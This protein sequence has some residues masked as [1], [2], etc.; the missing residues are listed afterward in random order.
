MDHINQHKLT[1]SEWCAIEIPVS[2]QE[3]L[4]LKMIQ[5]GYDNVNVKHNSHNSLFTFLKIEYSKHMEDYLYNKFFLDLVKELMQK[6]DAPFLKTVVDAKASIC[7]ADSIR[8]ERNAT[9][10]LTVDSVYELQL[11]T[12]I[13]KIL[14]YH[15]KRDDQWMH[16]YF[17][18]QKLVLNCVPLL[19]CNI[20]E[21]CKKVLKRFEEDIDYPKIIGNSVEYI[22]R[23]HLLL[24]YEDSSLYSHQKDIFT[25]VRD[26][27]PKLVL[28]IAPTGT[29]KTLSPIGLLSSSRKVIFVCAARH[30][31][32]ALARSAITMGKKVA[33]AFGCDSADDIRLHYNS[34][35]SFTKNRRTGGIFKV[36]NS[37]G[38]KVEMIICDIKSYLFAMYYMIAFTQK[39]SIDDE[40][41]VMT[42]E[43]EETI[44]E[45][46]F[47]Q[48]LTYWDEPTITMDYMEHEL[49]ETIHKNWRENLIPNMVLSSAT[50]PKIHEITETVADFREKFGAR[51]IVHSI[52]SHDCRKSIPIIDNDGFVAMPHYMNPLYEDV[53]ETV[54]HCENY[55]TILRYFDLSEAS[56]FITYVNENQLIPRQLMI[57]RRFGSLDDVNM[58]TIKLY[59]LE[60]LKNVTE[61][62]WPAIYAHFTRTR[63]RK[64]PYNVSIDVKGEKL[65][66]AQSADY[67]AQLK[68]H[69]EDSN[70][71]GALLSRTTSVQL[72]PPKNTLGPFPFNTNS[73]YMT[74]KDAH[75]L[76]D[77][78]TIFLTED[79]EKIAKFCIQQANIPP[80]IMGDIMEKIMQ[81]NVLNKK[82]GDIERELEDLIGEGDDG[83]TATDSD[84]TE[85]KK[86]RDSGT[87]NGSS[88]SDKKLDKKTT[89]KTNIRLMREELKALSGLVKRVTLNN[90]FVP[91][92]KEHVE[93]WATDIGGKN[94]FTGDVDEEIV[95]RIMLLDCVD[96]SLKVLLM[97]GIGVFKK[98]EN[99]EYTEI[100]KT[101]ADSQRL[102]MIITSSDYIYGTN[103]QFCHGYIGKDLNLTQ[104]KI[105]QAMGRIG[106]RNIQQSY[107]VRFR[108]NSQIEKL[109]KEATVK[110]E[111]I[112]MNRLFSAGHPHL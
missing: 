54:E 25:I 33:F 4:V 6:H 92:A 85:K 99:V 111:V 55:L 26:P 109:F 101:L 30:V 52:V 62:A 28:Y 91:N 110:P 89:N 105:L 31:G 69:K 44:M 51:T 29:G 9:D 48:L 97:M 27:S 2:A 39:P 67:V 74:T 75:T 108:D 72:P 90:T 13:D 56:K 82:I 53:L 100:M 65:S 61:G 68:M 86:G 59:Y 95:A 20:I 83:S 71:E 11:L 35:K 81:N 34:A 88:K 24:K 18:L 32:L 15:K 106:R 66:R 60:T 50:L 38:D 104:E 58:Q 103:Y 46:D 73:V 3:K 112:N 102:F 94:V 42:D 78:P 80:R 87:D 84:A 19:N 47:A 16:S 96:D 23:N 107:T 64:V 98:H 1:K 49:H 40:G 63:E 93:K 76:T 17:T 14:K 41:N 36:D 57:D 77:G 70:K 22:E 8:I 21:V 7:K 79:I 43:S 45:P 10:T 5:D 12:L 37:V